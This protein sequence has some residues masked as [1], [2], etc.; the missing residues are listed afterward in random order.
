MP[1][2]AW[3]AVGA[4]AGSLAIGLAPDAVAVLVGPAL[5]LLAVAA[6]ALGRGAASRRL[7]VLA[8]GVL[9]ITLRS[10]AA[11]E[12]KPTSSA[13]PA[14]DG[15]WV[16]TIQTVGAPRAGT[17]PA[18][19]L[20]ELEDAQP[21]RVAATLPW[22]PAVVPGDRVG[23][24]GRIRPPPD[25]EY[26]EYLAKIG[27]IGTLRADSVELLPATGTIE[28]MLEG[29]R[30]AA[31]TG[32]DRSM[33]EPEAGLAAGVLIGLR[34][35]VDRDLADAFTIAGASHVVAISGWNIAIVA[36]T[37]GALAGGLQ[38]RRR[39]VLT[40][41]AIVVYVAFVGPSPSVVRAGVMAGV[42]LLARELGRPGTAAAALGWAITGLLLIDPE[43]A[44]DAGFRL[45]VL[46]TA[47]IIAWGSGLTERLAGAAPTRPRRWVAEILGVSFAAQAATT[48][49]VLF[50][51]RAAVAGRAAGE[52]DRCPAGAAGDGDRCARA[53][54]RHARRRR[55]ATD[56][57]NR[58]RA[59]RVG[60]VRGDGRRGPDRRRAAAGE[61]RARCSLGW[62]RGRR[63]GVA[64][65]RCGEAR[66][67]MARKASGSSQSTDRRTREVAAGTGKG[68]GSATRDGGARS[69]RA[70]C[71]GSP[72]ARDD[73]ADARLRPSTRWAR[74]GRRA[75]RRAGRRDP[76]RRRSGRPARRRWWAGPV[77]APDRAGRAAASVGP[78]DRHP[79]AQPPARRPRGGTR[80]AA[81]AVQRGAGL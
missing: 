11:G 14:G 5:L 53:R 31:A 48:P 79:G 15:P 2:P 62:S 52:P 10:T 50:D 18:T 34:D 35:R 44:F 49:I 80:P 21:V 36:S 66:R 59:P 72:G 28:R 32:I 64:H 40:A 81:A 24:S 23:V 57:R 26:G 7:T 78:P 43:Y 13:I 1:R 8:V 29:F 65:L 6:H 56:P 16:A 60:P 12:P 42:A 70:A 54:R 58:R 76:R 33:P 77:A 9:A 19:M 30:R 3:L 37:L 61:P 4:T 74:S 51:V 68:K 17:R 55:R 22:F 41:I 73:R 27:A 39:A 38:R 25:D 69:D 46:A 45:S 63:L 47:G 20:L 75:G 71:G 67:S